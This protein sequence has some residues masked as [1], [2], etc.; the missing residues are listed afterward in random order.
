[1][2]RLPVR[3]R[4][5]AAGIGRRASLARRKAQPQIFVGKHTKSL[6]TS[7]GSVNNG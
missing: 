4:I 5:A 6:V 7:A 1:L 2:D 3:R